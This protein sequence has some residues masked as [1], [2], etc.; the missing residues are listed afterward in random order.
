[1]K[2][3]CDKKIVTPI[4]LGLLALACWLSCL[5]LVLI[6]PLSGVVAVVMSWAMACCLF[7]VVTSVLCIGKARLRFVAAAL[8][9]NILPVL[10]LAGLALWLV[11]SH[12]DS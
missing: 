12:L 6:G 5:V 10:A 7:G 11:L 2:S 3:E 1:M 8:A 9:L 4:A